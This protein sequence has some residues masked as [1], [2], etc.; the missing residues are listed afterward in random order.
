MCRLLG[1]ARSTFYAWAARADTLTATQARRRVLAGHVGAEFERSRQTSGC[2]RVAAALNR[3]GIP[4]S[5]GLVADLMR[6]RGLVAVQPRAYR[7]TTVH[8]EQ[9]ASV[10]DLLQRDFT[11]EAPGQR[12]VGDITHLATVRAGCTWPR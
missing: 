6:E 4:C 8:G 5:V 3:R 10:Q 12:L 1:V 11:A 9:P 7:R 2:R